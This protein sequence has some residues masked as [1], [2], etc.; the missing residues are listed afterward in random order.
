[1][2]LDDSDPL[3]ASVVAAI[4]GGD[5]AA[6]RDLLAA[7]PGLAAARM[8]RGWG[9]TLHVVT[10]WPGY[11]P[12]GPEAVRILIAAGADPNPP[13]GP[14]DDETPLHWAASSDDSDVAE[15]LI[16]AGA[17]LEAPGGSIGTPVENAVGYGC[18]NVARLLVARGARVDK[19]WVAA[20][21]GLL[22]RVADLL[23]AEPAPTEQDVNSAFWH[24]CSG[25][26]RR[27][28][29]LLLDHGADVN[30]TVDYAHGTALDAATGTDTRRSN[31][32][33][34]LRDRGARPADASDE[35]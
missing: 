32:I 13:R 9:S 7:H 14:D 25:A 15:V 1:V 21:L 26:Q 5:L 23:A 33:E 20:A 35:P 24:A 3:A 12:G 30:A 31:V 16:D 11:F 28:A 8:G 18:P 2:H 22:E 4:H 6:L 34:W 27:A 17:D 10:D 19:L 29:E